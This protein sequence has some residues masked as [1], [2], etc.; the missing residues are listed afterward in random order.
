[1]TLFV[2]LLAL[3]SLM[4]LVTASGQA[5]DVC[6]TTTFS[7]QSTFNFTGFPVSIATGDFNG[8]GKLD[9]A[10][11]HQGYAHQ[12]NP[13]QIY[14]YIGTGTGS[15]NAPTGY[16]TG[17]QPRSVVVADFNEDG[18]SD[19]AAAN[20]GESNLSVLLGTGTGSFGSHTTF[21]TG[22]SPDSVAIGDFNDDDHLD[23]AVANEG[24]H[25]VSLLLGAGNGS[26]G[27]PTNFATGWQPVF[28]AAGDFN[29][30]GKPDLA[31][32]NTVS[33]SVS[34][35]LGTGLGGF[36]SPVN[37]PTGTR[38]RYIA[39][40]DFNGDTVSDL[41]VSNE[42]SH[43]ISI[44]FGTG[45]GSFG[46]ANNRA[47]RQY[48]GPI[49]T[50]DF[51]ADGKPDLAVGNAS[52]S[53][54]SYITRVLG[55]GSDGFGLPANFNVGPQGS[56]P[57][58]IAIGDFNGDNKPD[59]V[60]ANYHS[61]TP[62]ISVLL[63]ISCEPTPEP[64]P[65]PSPTPT[66]TPDPSPSPF[67]SPRPTP[68]PSGPDGQIVFA[69]FVTNEQYE[70]FVMNADGSYPTRVT[71]NAYHSTDVIA[72]ES[73]FPAWSPDNSKI[74]F[75]MASSEHDLNGIYTIDVDGNNQKRLTHIFSDHPTWSPDGN[76]IAFSGQ[77]S[78]A[79]KS[80]IFIVNAD[81]TN[82][83]NITHDADQDGSPSWSPD[84]TKIAFMRYVD[85]T[86]TFDI[87]TINPDGSNLQNLT[88]TAAI[89]RNPAWSPNGL[90]MAYTSGNEIY[91]MDADGSNQGP[92]PNRAFGQTPTWS[93]DGTKIV[94]MVGG[95][96]SGELY[97]MNA[98]GSDQR[99]ITNAPPQT[100][101]GD[102]AGSASSGIALDGSRTPNWQRN[103]GPRLSV[104]D[105]KVTEGNS[106]TIDATF[107][108]TLSP[109]S[110]KVVTVHYATANSTASAASDYVA[111][112]GNL[113][114]NP[115]QVSRTVTVK[116]NGDMTVEPDEKFFLN[117]TNST[118]APMADAQGVGTITNN[119]FAGTLQFSTTA[120]NAQESGGSA[121]V[122]VTRTGG[123]LG[124]VTVAYA[125]I[126]NTAT[127]R[128]DFTPATGSLSF[129]PGQMSRTFTV[130]INNDALDEATENLS[131][132]LSNPT[133]GSSLGT[134][135]TAS[136]SISDDD[137][138]PSLSIGDFTAT[139]GD[140]YT[141]VVAN[142]T[143]R[144]SAPSGQ[145]VA[146]KYQTA[147]GTA[148]APADYSAVP[149]STL[150]F[151]PGQ[152]VR[153]V[154]VGISPDVLDEPNETFRLVLSS[155]ANATIT[156]TT[157]TCIIRDNDLPPSLHVSNIELAETNATALANFTVSLSAPSGQ[158]VTVKYATSNGTATAPSDYAARA[159]TALTF[160]PGQ[161]TKTVAISVMGDRLSEATENF[162]LS[163]YYPTNAA[164]AA[165][166]GTCTITDND[167]AP[168][169][170]S[171]ATKTDSRASSNAFLRFL[172]GQTTETIMVQFKGDLIGKALKRVS[173]ST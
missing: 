147:N 145:T 173:S 82:M 102:D 45:S 89:E 20:L 10:V 152:T 158:T 134:R 167:P 60:T 151:S 38:P 148:T 93:P 139:E 128:A 95:G 71:Y 1:M 132:K 149:L 51:N 143:V 31:V 100:V 154:S 4:I 118:N 106:G 113:T 69:S 141:G 117:L 142:F 61:S 168:S 150:Y 70:L 41:A 130:P 105:I 32:A 140:Y 110:N 19:L 103:L 99:P 170:A 171:S 127:S 136:L 43:N 22:T 108:V 87:F 162:K 126:G 161:T 109:A 112:S 153:N 76:R 115:G 37:Y 169:S 120:Y 21:P 133:G 56:M 104:N 48:P 29:A 91:L 26:F 44:L 47:I 101:K 14:V 68:P 30:D 131:L 46:A 33:N 57:L 7:E 16:L 155:P 35:L 160:L 74:A 90:K 53:T 172:P 42:Q 49:V 58:T 78:V 122:T 2:S 75:R 59:L 77:D 11:A 114:F 55:A 92:L 66:P 6:A 27:A 39:I 18:K 144:L 119:D 65:T 8:D 73:D 94:F 125:T 81:G 166:T 5:V 15:F 84:G 63:N 17:T 159:L 80:D 98:D 36:N 13:N 3:S 34:I 62:S 86:D 121:T 163:L 164:I 96:D 25:N 52:T 79:F 23:L 157:G 67:P 135:S 88:N 124:T 123:S 24:S 111:A 85:A 116:V 165:G 72:P 156:N 50:G 107:T 97:V 40:G 146:V 129:A 9:L 28:V 54:G 138:P 137:S 64:A 12:G 83:V